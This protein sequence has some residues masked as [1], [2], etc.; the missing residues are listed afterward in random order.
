MD[1]VG[2]KELAEIKQELNSIIKELEDISFSIRNDFEGIG[3]ERCADT[4]DGV[5]NQY[6]V[7][8][9]KLKNIDVEKV[10]EGYSV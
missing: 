10:A 7:V 8:Q 2:Q 4:I 1:A 9:K 6:Y 3:N 5:L